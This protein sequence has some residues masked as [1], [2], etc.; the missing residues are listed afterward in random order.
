LPLSGDTR[1]LIR[2]T[3]DS[4]DPKN[5]PT[6]IDFGRVPINRHLGFSLLSIEQGAAEVAMPL[7]R[8]FLQEEGVVHGGVITTLADTAAVYTVYPFL[9]EGET[10][11]SIEFKLNFLRPAFLDD[12]S[13]TAKASLV[14]HG[15]RVALVEVD[16]FQARRL[17][18]K[19]LFTYLVYPRKD[20]SV[21]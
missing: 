21:A 6:A 1:T 2:V 12:G 11:T 7:K 18:A 3:A 17:V 14:R 9:A 19:G 8:F 4:D 5:L 13:V 15:R 10:M 16:V 20:V